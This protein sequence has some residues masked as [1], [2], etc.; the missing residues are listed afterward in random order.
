MNITI[1]QELRGIYYDPKIGYQSMENLYQKAR[2]A[3]LQVSRRKIE[4][5]LPAHV[6]E[7]QTFTKKGIQVPENLCERISRSTSN[8][9]CRYGKISLQKQRLL[10]DFN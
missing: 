8:G 10:L 2:S 3:G 6:Y 1:E 5:W 7:I 4:E 9:S